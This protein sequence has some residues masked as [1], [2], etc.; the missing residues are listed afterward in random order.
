[1]CV[2]GIKSVGTPA[3]KCVASRFGVASR[4]WCQIV[5]I[6][7]SRVA[8]VTEVGR[9]VECDLVVCDGIVDFQDQSTGVPDTWYWD[10]GD[11]ATATTQ[12]PSHTYSALG[13]YSV[14]EIASNAYGSDTI[15]QTVTLTSQPVVAAFSTNQLQ[16]CSSPATIDFTNNSTNASSYDWD[17]DDGNTSQAENPSHTF[18]SDGDYTV[19]LTANSLLC[20]SDTETVNTFIDPANVIEENMPV[21]TSNTVTCCH[22][23][24]YDDGGAANN[25]EDK[26]RRW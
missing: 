26:I 17:F 23:T 4:T 15:T 1:L 8:V 10:F 7:P 18:L 5:R 22:G 3:G 16:F 20:G 21:N 19:L 24:L 13:T 25:Y 14:T 2:P 6:K 11:G 9:L 12:N